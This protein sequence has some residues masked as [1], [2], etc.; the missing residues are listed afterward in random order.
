MSLYLCVVFVLFLCVHVRLFVRFCTC[1]YY[2]IVS[3]FTLFDFA[4]LF[5]TFLYYFMQFGN[6]ECVILLLLLSHLLCAC[7]TLHDSVRFSAQEMPSASNVED[8]ED[9][10]EE[11]RM[12]VCYSLFHAVRTVRAP[13]AVFM[14]FCFVITLSYVVP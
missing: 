9:Y 11:V 2:R 7:I 14:F 3:H 12:A 6:R 1:L 5:F 10:G 8:M 4:L 13:T